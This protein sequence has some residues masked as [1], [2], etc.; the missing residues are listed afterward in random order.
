MEFDTREDGARNAS[1]VADMD[2]WARESSTWA[3]AVAQGRSVK[4]RT[5]PRSCEAK[6]EGAESARNM[7]F[8][9]VGTRRARSF[10]CLTDLVRSI[11]RALKVTASSTGRQCAKRGGIGLGARLEDCGKSI[12]KCAWAKTG[13]ATLSPTT[14]NFPHPSSRRTIASG[15]SLKRSSAYSNKSSAGAKAAHRK[16]GRK[17]HTYISDFTPYVSRKPKH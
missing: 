12:M 11:L 15:S 16:H 2:G 17:S 10:I 7:C 1:C 5:S 6:P 14:L 4:G 9:I 3:K 13:D 8:L